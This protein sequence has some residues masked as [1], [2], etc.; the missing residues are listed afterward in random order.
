MTIVIGDTG[1]I[2]IDPLSSAETAARWRSPSR[3]ASHRRSRL[4]VAVI[5]TH[6]APADHFGGVRGVIDHG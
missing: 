1:L 3:A 2:I 5:Y 6:S 4:C